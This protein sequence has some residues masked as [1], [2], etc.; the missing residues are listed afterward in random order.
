[1]EKKNKVFLIIGYCLLGLLFVF[2]I[3]ASVY[4]LTDNTEKIFDENIFKVVEVKSLVS[5]DNWGICNR[6]LY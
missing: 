4:F 6:L 3:F 1:M 2:N 5:E